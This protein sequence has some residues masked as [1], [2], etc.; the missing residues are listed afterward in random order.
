MA[1]WVTLFRSLFAIGLGVAL[2]FNQEMARPLL[3]NFMGAYWV[4]AG[5]L[6]LRWGPSGER[7]GKSSFL[8]GLIGILAGLAVIGRS[9]ALNLVDERL[10]I[11]T[12][13]VVISLTGLLH[14]FTGFQTKEGGRRRQWASTLLGGFEVILGMILFL[15]P[16]NRDRPIL[17]L[18]AMLWGFLGGAI[19]MFDALRVR[20]KLR[21]EKKVGS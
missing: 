16:L 14:I 10:V 12:L 11:M 9:L 4:S 7:G 5:I 8:I 6:S 3:G 17:L 20:R 19:L 2:L 13:A 18:A 1:F 21:E 15:E